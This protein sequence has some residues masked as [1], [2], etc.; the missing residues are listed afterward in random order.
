MKKE[1]VFCNNC[2]FF[3]P[4]TGISLSTELCNAPG[5]RAPSKKGNTYY[6]NG[7]MLT[8][9]LSAPKDINKNTNCTFYQEEPKKK[10]NWWNLMSGHIF[11][12]GW[13]CY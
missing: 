12:D 7:I 5:N 4:G 1:E 3:D 2:K 10:K 11:E 13:S 6:R 8:G 9:F